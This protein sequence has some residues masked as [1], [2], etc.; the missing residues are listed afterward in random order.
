MA[1]LDKIDSDTII[2]TDGANLL[3][4]FSHGQFRLENG[5]LF[6][7]DSIRLKFVSV[8]RTILS[9]GDNGSLK[10]NYLSVSANADSEKSGFR[11]FRNAVITAISLNLEKAKDCTVSIRRNHNI[12]NLVSISNVPPNFGN[13]IDGLNIDLNTGDFLQ[14]YLASSQNIN[15]PVLAAEIAWRL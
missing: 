5:I 7:Y 9:F 4:P 11:L 15:N 8:D 12:I 6:V 3:E 2:L 13:Q 10:N 14:A 1:S